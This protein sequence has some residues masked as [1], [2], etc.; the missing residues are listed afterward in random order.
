MEDI[1]ALPN[2][3]EFTYSDI[4]QAVHSDGQLRF[5]VRGSKI[6]LKPPELNV[7]NSFYFTGGR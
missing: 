4:H 3:Q 7:R 6:R 1:L 2:F 5:S